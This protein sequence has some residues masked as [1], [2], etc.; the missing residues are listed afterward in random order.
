MRCDVYRILIVTPVFFGDEGFIL[1][2]LSSV[3]RQ[4]D[5]PFDLCQAF[6][7]DRV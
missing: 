3:Q 2:N 6:V 7:N 1:Q 5:L 4:T